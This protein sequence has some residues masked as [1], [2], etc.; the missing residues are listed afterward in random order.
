MPKKSAVVRFPRLS[1]PMRGISRNKETLSLYL[2]DNTHAGGKCWGLV[3]YGVKSNIIAYYILGS[4]DPTAASTLYDL[5]NF[6]A[7][8]SILRMIIT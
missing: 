1:D 8:N 2:L 7:E 4:K 5:G 3:F 6:M